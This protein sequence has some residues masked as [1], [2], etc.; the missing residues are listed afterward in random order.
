METAAKVNI[1]YRANAIINQLLTSSPTKLSNKLNPS[2]ASSTQP[3]SIPPPIAYTLGE[4]AGIGADIIIQLAQLEQLDDIVCIGDNRLLAKRAEQIGLPLTLLDFSAELSQK[5]SL[6]VLS[7]PVCDFD[8]AGKPNVDNVESVLE[9]LN[10]AIDGCMEGSFSAMVTGPLHKGIINDAGILFSGH[11]EYLAEQSAAELP[12]MMLATESLRVALITTHLPLK[13][14]S[15]AITQAKI[16]QVCRIIHQDMQQKYAIELPR[17]LVCGLNPHAGED[18]HLGREEIDTIIPALE[19]LRSDGLDVIGPL[20]ADTLF[21]P[22]YLQNADVVVAM[23]HDQGLPVLKALGF[24]NAA[25]ITLGLPFVRTSVDHG[26][27][28][29]L[30]GTGNAEIGSL[31]TAITVARQIRNASVTP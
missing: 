14:V 6:R 15:A 1:G 25:N 30:A 12:V 31:K 21:T 4:P 5:G 2:K 13:D 16:K 3:P 27:A 24:G 29:D 26:T 8:V 28:F 10:T 17:L 19:E 9:M 11:T 22:R 18:G 7:Q 23:Y 20:P